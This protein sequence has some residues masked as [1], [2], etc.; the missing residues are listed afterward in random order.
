MTD[1][2][3]NRYKD[4]V[5]YFVRCVF[6]KSIE[7]MS[8]YY[9]GLDGKINEHDWKNTWQLILLFFHEE[10]KLPSAQSQNIQK[11]IRD[12]KKCKKH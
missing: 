5:N 3:I 4:F 7:I 8:S 9:Y 10:K 6:K 11:K 12:F 1:L 2:K